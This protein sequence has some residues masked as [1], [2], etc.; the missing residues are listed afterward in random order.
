MDL[1][2]ELE[3]IVS[4][5]KRIPISIQQKNKNIDTVDP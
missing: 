3:L 1:F 5:N 2:T 4:I